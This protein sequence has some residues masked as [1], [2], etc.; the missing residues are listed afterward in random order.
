MLSASEASAFF[1][2]LQK[3]IFGPPQNDVFTDSANEPI[4]SY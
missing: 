3:Q 1:E 4:L 2:S